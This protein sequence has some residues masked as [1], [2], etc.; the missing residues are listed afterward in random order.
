MPCDSDER[1]LA[2][3]CRLNHERGE[4]AA[5]CDRA[6]QRAVVCL[7]AD[8]ALLLLEDL[9]AVGHADDDG[10][11]SEV[12]ADDVKASVAKLKEKSASRKEE[13]KSRRSSGNVEDYLLGGGKKEKK[14]KKEK[15]RKKS[16]D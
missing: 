12:G 9:V 14:E 11:V 13:E 3:L 2:E 16:S 10:V 4:V 1:G 7:G 15:K 5:E 8:G 6:G